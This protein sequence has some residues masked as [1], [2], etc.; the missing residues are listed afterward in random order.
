MKHILFISLLIFTIGAKGQFNSKKYFKYNEVDGWIKITE[1]N[2]FTVAQN[3]D[4]TFY[5]QTTEETNQENPNEKPKYV[6][7]GLGNIVKPDTVVKIVMVPVKS[8]PATYLLSTD[9]FV[10]ITS[11]TQYDTLVYEKVKT[12]YKYRNRKSK[13]HYAAKPKKEK[14]VPV[15]YLTYKKSLWLISASFA[16]INFSKVVEADSAAKAKVKLKKR[17]A[18]NII[19]VEQ[20]T[21]FDIL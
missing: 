18:C 17:I 3:G 10:S 1:T 20:F 2:W 9:S 4:T 13:K 11:N 21:Q 15:N 8:K 14:Y 6:F 7:D 16:G 12:K 19:A 5:S